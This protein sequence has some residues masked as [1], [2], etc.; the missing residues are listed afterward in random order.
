M[1]SSVDPNEVRLTGENSFMRLSPAGGD[2]VTT[3]VSHWRVLFSPGGSGHVLFLQ[4]ELTDNRPPSTP[5]K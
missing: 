4:S 3:Q 1:A 5:I 2:P